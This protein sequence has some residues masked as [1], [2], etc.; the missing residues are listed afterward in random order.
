V[1]VR[2]AHTGTAPR[3]TRR[4]PRARVRFSRQAGGNSLLQ[5][6]RVHVRDHQHVARSRIGDDTGDEPI[7]VEFG[8]QRAAFLDLA[9]ESVLLPFRTGARTYLGETAFRY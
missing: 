2:R 3:C 8:R 1:L 7:G 5:C 9:C 6:L 4:D